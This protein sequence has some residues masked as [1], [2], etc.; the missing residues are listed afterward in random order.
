MTS[1]SGTG[2][3]CYTSSAAPAINQ[4]AVSNVLDSDGHDSDSDDRVGLRR[5]GQW[6]CNYCPVVVVGL[7]VVE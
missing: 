3:Y 2:R 6:R 1:P 5:L 4:V 7:G